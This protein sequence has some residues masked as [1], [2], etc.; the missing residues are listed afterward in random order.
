MDNIFEIF[1]QHSKKALKNAY[2]CA[3]KNKNKQIEIEH[4]LLAIIKE[5]GSIGSEILGQ[6][7]IQT[8]TIEKNLAGGN[9]PSQRILMPQLSSVSKKAIERAS[10]IA[11]ANEHQYVGTEHLL[12]GII[13]VNDP[14]IIEIFKDQKILPKD[15]KNK[16]KLVLKSTSN[17]PEISNTLNSLPQRGDDIDL[18]RYA[19]RTHKK[20]L[21]DFFAIHLTDKKI[22]K[23]ID[24]V[25]GRESE[26]DRI[27]QILC[28]RTKNNPLLLGDP[29][30]GKTAI[31]E[32]LA[33]KISLGD[34]PEILMNKKIY[35]LDL[36]L[37]IAGS[38][39]RGE[40]EQR[41]KQIIQ[42][43]KTDQ[44][45]ILFI[46]EIHNIVG[47]GAAAGSMDAANILKPS[48][49]RG[50]IR[51]I[52][53]TTMEEYKKHIEN[54]PAFERRFQSIIVNE[55]TAEK[56]I[57][58]L[59]GIKS[60]YE[61]FHQVEITDEAIRAAVYLAQ[62]YFQEKFFPDKAIDLIDEAAS[63]VK[64]RAKIQ[65][66]QA[67][68]RELEKES[69]KTSEE[70]KR[71]VISE[72]YD[73]ALGLRQKEEEITKKI[74]DIKKKN[75]HKKIIITS[76]ITDIEIKEIISKIT[77]IPLKELDLEKRK[78]L[79]HLEDRLG[80]KIIGQEEAVKIV[81]EYMRRAWA[82]INDV[83]RP[84]GSFI[85]LG[86]SGVGKTEL[87]K[88][89]A[90]TVFNDP[91]ALIRIDM[92]EFSE[93]FNIS[94][95]IGSPAGYIGYKDATN[96]T[97]RVRRKP[98]S[99]VLFDEIE[100]AHPQIFNLLLQ[101]LEDGN[102]TDASGKTVNFKNT[103]IIMTSNIGSDIFNKKGALGFNSRNDKEA[104]R[105]KNE[106]D[107][108]KKLVMEKLSKFFRIEFL[109]RI[110]KVIVFK[111]LTKQSIEKIADINLA[112]LGKKLEAKGI[113]MPY[114]QDIIE[115][116]GKTSY[117]PNVGARA[118]RKNIL[119][120]IENAIAEKILSGDAMRKKYISLTLNKNKILIK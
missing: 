94:K 58:I 15:I 61:K 56:T 12:F 114:G 8:D 16:I 67:Q 92:S 9:E 51:C 30:V 35:T 78:E 76:R 27:I 13:E 11:S 55:P 42:E 45:I 108:T 117:A 38:S 74:E 91:K 32:G 105:A 19:M 34:V 118:I 17:F 100:K 89:L 86:P 109:N 77:N 2:M 40:F 28:R 57:E 81:S 26:I 3:L 110:D 31:V 41:L 5:K 97:D 102:I 70:K 43:V 115:Y 95:L 39:F 14:K 53:A 113:S 101:I 54:D 84:I 119:E 46:D 59:S 112:K 79:L 85:F 107:D 69:A 47:A 88:T 87:A 111:P 90:H 6:V 73:T 60:H 80:E 24:P 120:L 50:E 36:G 25:I 23:N 20:S 10:L 22:Q 52:G 7:K 65:I 116:I 99:V 68:I 93:S 64:V 98:H 44:N 18:E 104:E 49:A 83:D 71:A 1:S 48:L 29:G 21:L 62:R 37:L 66:H 103:I 96:L 63:G 33:K 72:D 82:G 75:L 4:I 106:F